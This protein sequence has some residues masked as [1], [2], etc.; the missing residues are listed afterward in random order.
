[1]ERFV[2]FDF[3]TKVEREIPLERVQAAMAEGRFV[4]LDIETRDRERV[5]ALLTGQL[6]L[7]KE[8][9]ERVLVD[10]V[11]CSYNAYPECL[12]LEL[13]DCRLD[14]TELTT[15]PIDVVV[16]ERFL[17]T[18]SLEHAEF[19]GGV[20]RSYQSDFVRFAQSPSFL[21]YEIWDHL[22][23]S[24][25]HVEK[26]FDAKVERIQARLMGN[27]KDEVFTDV[28]KLSSDLL[29][30]RQ[31]V[32]PARG[33]L[34]ELATRKSLFVSEATQ[35]FLLE[36][37]TRI[38][39][40][41]ADIVVNRDIVRDSIDLYMSIVGYRTNKVMTRLTL[42]TM[43]FLPLSFLSGIYGMEFIKDIPEI[44]WYEF[45][46]ICVTLSAGVLFVLY[47]LRIL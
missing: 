33:V 45:W 32:A 9:I 47:R 3:E 18:F 14:Q 38:E 30:F 5:G 23:R 13:I 20:R 6:E 28:S 46:A 35:P 24:Y 16:G 10:Q 26:G 37:A 17:V 40:I 27:V 1:M 22:I 43:I 31:Q 29:K 44:S 42:V 15:R 39:R 4:W 36:M 7:R 8:V 25:E 11:D 19:L 21:I 34:T 2:E 41:I 12:H